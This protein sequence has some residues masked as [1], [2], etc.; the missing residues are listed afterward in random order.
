M[1]KVTIANFSGGNAP[2]KYNGTNG[3]YSCGKG[4]DIHSQPGK[5]QA[6]QALTKD[7]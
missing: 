3:S 6:G 4:L 5:L 1:S 2:S 7:S